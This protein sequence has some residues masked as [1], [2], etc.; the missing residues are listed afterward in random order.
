MS[1]LACNRTG[2]DRIMCDRHSVEYGYICYECFDELVE[3]VSFL[4]AGN[5]Q[6]FMESHKGVHLSDQKKVAEDFLNTVFEKQGE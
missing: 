2:C 3:A 1:V 4:P 6:R 5:I